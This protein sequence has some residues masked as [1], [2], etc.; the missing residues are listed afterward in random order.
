MVKIVG[1]RCAAGYAPENT[2]LSFQAAIQPGCDRAELD[3][4]ISKDRE[5]IVFHDEEVSR[6]TKGTGFVHELSL[7]ELKRLNCPKNQK[8]PTLQEVMGFC[9]GKIDLQIELKTNGTPK[10][11]AKVLSENN[12][13][14]NA[15][16]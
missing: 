1:H 11:V 4:R 7:A 5:V 9:W 2:L 3:V 14:E 10:L 15:V 12:F 13:T 8:I 16:I 6:L